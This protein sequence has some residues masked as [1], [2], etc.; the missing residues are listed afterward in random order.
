MPLPGPVADGGRVRAVFHCFSNGPAEAR[1]LIDLGHL[2]SFTG[3]VTY[4]NAAEVQKAATS[5]P[6]DSFMVE[7]DAPYL[8]PVPRRGKRCEPAFTR[9]TAQHIAALRRIPLRDLADATSRTAEN[10]FSLPEM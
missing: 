9:F 5:V 2:V 1:R 8:A 4:P 6:L 3:I 10:F 7:T